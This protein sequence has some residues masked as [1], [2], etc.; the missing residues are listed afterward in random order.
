MA[1]HTLVAIG[2]GGSLSAAHL[3]ATLHS[4]R[5][6][7]LATFTTPLEFSRGVDTSV[8][9]SVLLLS[10]GGRNP[11]ILSAF[12][13]AA[14]AEVAWI[15]AICGVIGSPL[16]KL[17]KANEFTS[18]VEYA[19]PAG[20]DGF[21]ATNSL[22]AV[23]TLLVRAFGE[24]SNQL[25]STFEE[26]IGAADVDSF[27][28]ATTVGSIEDLVERE[29]LVVLY[30]P[31]TK[32]AALD[33]ESKLTEAALARVQL[34]DYRNFGHGRHHWFAKRAKESALLA[35]AAPEDRSLC[36]R[37]LALLPSSIPKVIAK[38]PEISSALP[39]QALLYAFALTKAFGDARGID[40][41]R[42]SVPEFG[43]KLYHLRERR[44]RQVQTGT[45][46]AAVRRKQRVAGGGE[47]ATWRRYAEE[48][49][50]LL[51]NTPFNAVVFDY[52]GTLC[53]PKERFLGP[54]VAISS[55]I[56]RL[57]KGG[58]RL[59][60]ATGRGRSVRTDLQKRVPKDFWKFVLIGYY[61]GSEIGTLADN[62]CPD[63]TESTVENLGAV[64]QSLT[65]DPL[66]EQWCNY[67]VRRYQITL[68]PRESF[69]GSRLWQRAMEHV[70]QIGAQGVK[71]VSS[72]HSVDIIAPE[73][74]KI[75]LVNA[76]AKEPGM[77]PEHKILCIGDRGRWPGND[78][79]LL[80][81][82][83]ALSTD[84]V[85]GDPLTCW[86]FAPAGCRGTQATHF[87][88]ASA[89]IASGK[90]QLVLGGSR[91]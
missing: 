91:K 59:A 44:P 81:Q 11:D 54:S 69:T 32:G 23:S 19:I 5:T 34:T 60:I 35:L 62:G 13:Q 85:S 18:L 2:S 41:G 21:L 20:K 24:T 86:N 1:S 68:E 65:L 66:L 50:A 22:L 53:G 56:V 74:S 9:S 57:L 55:Q 14:E 6:G 3:A 47:T 31:S 36:E 71:V 27:L 16:A 40:P 52:D 46:E 15:G 84:E 78:Y 87:Y 10:A 51:Q 28:K 58:V 88:L 70:S 4:K 80:H 73:A 90:V 33:L 8:S 43:R 26:L 17:A 37:T 48:H 30:G 72:T 45:L 42:P 89:K 77:P 39:L 75:N 83:F 7:Q 12:R 63:R 64:L 38:L 79:E 76:L 61:N 67:S 29:S 25:P 82:P 49:L